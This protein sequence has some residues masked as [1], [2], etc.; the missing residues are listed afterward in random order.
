MLHVG[1]LTTIITL[2]TYPTKEPRDTNRDNLIAAAG[3]ITASKPA[4]NTRT[5]P[6]SPADKQVIVRVTEEMQELWRQAAVI[7]GVSLSE[8]IRGLVSKYADGVVNCPHPANMIKWYPWSEQCLK[9]GK[10]LR[11]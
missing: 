5:V 2:M 4:A 10:R 7:D 3:H 11:A 6:G 9:C 8:M 1:S